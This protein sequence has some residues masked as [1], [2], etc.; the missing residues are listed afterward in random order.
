MADARARAWS[1]MQHYLLDIVKSEVDLVVSPVVV[2]ALAAVL[3][4]EVEVRGREG[5]KAGSGQIQV[6]RVT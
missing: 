5:G 2:S 4:V 6:W 3:V 1:V